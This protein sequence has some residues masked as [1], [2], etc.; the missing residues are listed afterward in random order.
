MANFF[1]GFC[2][3]AR[4]GKACL[5][6]SGIFQSV[7]SQYDI[8][9]LFPFSGSG[10]TNGGF[11]P[12]PKKPKKYNPGGALFAVP[13]RLPDFNLPVQFRALLED[14][15]SERYEDVACR[16][17]ELEQPL[18]DKNYPEKF[19]VS[20]L[21]QP[22]ALSRNTP[23]VFF[24]FSFSFFFSFF[25]TICKVTTER[26]P[27]NF[28]SF[29]SVCVCVLGIAQFAV[30]SFASHLFSFLSS[31]CGRKTLCETLRKPRKQRS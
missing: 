5:N 10:G 2:Q 1:I 29:F 20:F 11:V 25:S 13:K 17:P 28:L 4:L 7:S 24:S 22:Q 8:L 27:R 16:F 9:L 19:K 12:A 3:V 31:A 15:S 14:T 30:Y 6:L 26:S 18:C 23:H 21:Q